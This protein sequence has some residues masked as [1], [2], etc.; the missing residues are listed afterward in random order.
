MAGRG[1]VR[2]EQC[3]AAGRRVEVG[4]DTVVLMAR[5]SQVRRG[6]VAPAGCVRGSELAA[7]MSLWATR[8]LPFGHRS[9]EPVSAGANVQGRPHDGVL[10]SVCQ[11]ASRLHE[12]RIQGSGPD[13]KGWAHA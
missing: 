7:G 5:G 3:R 13:T 9:S 2:D 1:G 6:E 10:A 12:K 4:Q 11:G 8:P